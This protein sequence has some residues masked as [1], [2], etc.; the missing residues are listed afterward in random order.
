MDELTLDTD[1]VFSLVLT[2]PE[3]EGLMASLTHTQAMV[4]VSE[5]MGVL[6]SAPGPREGEEEGGTRVELS[7]EGCLVVALLQQWL[8]RHLCKRLMQLMTPEAL[9][10]HRGKIPSSYLANYL[11]FHAHFSLKDLV[12]KY[13][14]ALE[15]L[16]L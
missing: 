9:V 10:V 6:H 4:A 14:S 2:D 11:A 15:T 7:A 13:S 3:F 16:E 12:G 1:Q 5:A 8:V